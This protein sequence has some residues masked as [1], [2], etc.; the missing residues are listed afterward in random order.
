MTTFR[1]KAIAGLAIAVIASLPILAEPTIG[2]WVQA[3]GGS[4]LGRARPW[5]D[6]DLTVITQAEEAYWPQVSAL[7]NARA[8]MVRVSLTNAV[9][10]AEV[11]A[12]AQAVADAELA[13]ALSKADTFARLKTQLGA[14]N[15]ERAQELASAMSSVTGGGGGGGR[16]GAPAPAAA[17][18]GGA[19][20]GRGN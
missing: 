4:G 9:N 19:P 6:R 13:L 2:P 16:G 17:A 15:P 1:M 14:T 5:N 12:A 8:E 20:A 10:S 7:T 3:H 18:R 11:R